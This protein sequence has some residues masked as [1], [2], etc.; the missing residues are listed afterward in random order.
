M[1]TKFDTLY[2]NTL[3]RYQQGGFIAG[4]RIRFKKDT[5]KHDFFKDKG[6][7]FVDLVKSCMQDGFDKIMRVSVLKSIYPTT[8]QNYRGGTESPDKI[9]VD[10]VIETNPGLYVSPMTVPIEVLD[11]QDDE[12]GRGPVPDSLKRKSESTMPEKT[13]A[14]KTSGEDDSNINLTTKNT[15]IKGGKKWDDKKAGGGNFTKK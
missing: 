14:K 3:G 5:L 4:D 1:E 7:N 12:G 15:V 2:E 9:Y 8:T 13:E 11:L 10:V 6:Q